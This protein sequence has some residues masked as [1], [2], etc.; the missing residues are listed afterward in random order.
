MIEIG[1]V[2]RIEGHPPA[3]AV[4]VNGVHMHCTVENLRRLL[5]APEPFPA[6]DDGRPV[7]T[8]EPYGA[9]KATITAE[10]G[11]RLLTAIRGL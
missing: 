2:I 4:V 5:E 11:E 6:M 8:L 1:G 7:L 9:V 10:D 3:V